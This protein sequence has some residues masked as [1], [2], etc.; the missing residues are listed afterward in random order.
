MRYKR[1]LA[2]ILIVS[3]VLGLAPIYAKA[4]NDSAK[5][6]KQLEETRLKMER[7]NAEKAKA[8]K[9][10]RYVAQQI[11]NL[12][13]KLHS[14][15]SA[16]ANVEKN[17]NNLEGQL[18]V[19]KRELERA[20]ES[21]NNHK[22]LLKKRIR[23]MYEHGNVGYV[24]VILNSSSFTDFISNMDFLKKIVDNDMNILKRMKSYRAEIKEKSEQ[25]AKDYKEKERLKLQMGN[26]K[27]SV[28]CTLEEMEK[29]L[30]ELNS[31]LKELEKQID[32]Q[33]ELSNQLE[34]KIAAL[35]STEKYIGGALGWP[36]PGNFKISSSYGYR[37]HPILKK[38]KMHT[39]IDIHTPMGADIVAANAGKVLLSAYN[40]GYGY[41][42]IIDHGGK[43]STLYAHNSKLLVKEGEQ[44]EKGQLIAKAGSTGLSTG[45]HLHFEV[46]ENGKH[47]DPMGYLTKKK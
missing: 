2:I 6:R 31:D 26:Q 17:L 16:L 38:N 12:D 21:E 39:G 45:P 20:S 15:Q 40:G 47:V 34:K 43:I 10:K 27:E 4:P 25:I 28:K 37:L 5:L 36:A 18:T 7:L 32:A 33:N 30:K 3:V 23:A 1:F 42:I 8:T 29:A 35:Q 46:R 19:T 11:R 44:V 22:E 24:S 14:V 13:E 9:E 41:C